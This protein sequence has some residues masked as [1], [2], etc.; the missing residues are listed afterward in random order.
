MAE[1]KCCHSV[2]FFPGFDF[3]LSVLFKRLAM[4]IASP[5]GTLGRESLTQLIN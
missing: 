2:L 1:V 5:S 4:R 3:V